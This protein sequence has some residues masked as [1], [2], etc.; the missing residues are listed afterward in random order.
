MNRCLV[1]T[2][3]AGGGVC[4]GAAASEPSVVLKC[5]YYTLG[6]GGQRSKVRLQVG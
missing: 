1:G 3:P 2:V 4:E 6:W 5:H